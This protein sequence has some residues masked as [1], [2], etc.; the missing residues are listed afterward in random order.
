MHYAVLFR[1]PN[2]QELQCV[3]PQMRGIPTLSKPQEERQ[4]V[5]KGHAYPNQQCQASESPGCIR[6][7]QIIMP[8]WVPGRNE[9]CRLPPSQP[10][11]L[12]EP[13]RLC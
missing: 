10:W 1:S 9:L 3:Y 6:R 4:Q 13:I 11:R 5:L 2:A 8:S 7:I 12:L